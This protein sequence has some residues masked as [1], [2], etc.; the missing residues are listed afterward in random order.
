MTTPAPLDRRC[1][2]PFAA[3]YSQHG[4]ARLIHATAPDEFWPKGRTGAHTFCG[5]NAWAQVAAA[6]RVLDPQDQ[7]PARLRWCPVC[8]HHWRNHYHGG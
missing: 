6:K 5:Q 7:P 4:L 1:E 2:E 8:L 3:W